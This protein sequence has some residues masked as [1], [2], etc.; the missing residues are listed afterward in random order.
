MLSLGIVVPRSNQEL[1]NICRPENLAHINALMPERYRR[2][3]IYVNTTC[4]ELH[5]SLWTATFSEK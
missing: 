1:E 2:H 3:V 4:I 5:G